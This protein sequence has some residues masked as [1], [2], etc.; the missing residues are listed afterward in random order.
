MKQ[1]TTIDQ[2][3]RM[4]VKGFAETATKHDIERLDKRMDGFDA[5]MDGLDKRMDRIELKIAHIEARIAQIERDIAEIRKSLI[6]RNELEDI[7]GRI[8]YI[9]RKLGIISGAQ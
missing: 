3:A 8:S 9:E 6:S 7:L 5:R 4:I 2:L 1:K